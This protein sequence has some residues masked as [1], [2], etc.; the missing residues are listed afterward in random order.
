MV[1]RERIL[2][3]VLLPAPLRPMIPTTSPAATLNVTSR[4]A[5][6]VRAPLARFDDRPRRRCRD[7]AAACDIASRKDPY[8]N[9]PRADPN[10]YCFP[11]ASTRIVSDDIGE[12]MFHPLE[13]HHAAY[14]EDGGDGNG[15]SDELNR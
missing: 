7:R 8:V 9:T 2:S 6:S 12:G 15:R 11:S 10:W 4:S 13:H 14:E 1:M 3:S 5:Q